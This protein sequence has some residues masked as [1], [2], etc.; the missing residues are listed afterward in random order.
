MKVLLLRNVL[1]GGIH[2]QAGSTHDLGDEDG[3][4]LIRMGKAKINLLKPQP[5]RK[6][7][8]ED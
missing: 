7:K 6:P 2:F 1:V 8:A 5:L 4:L 3:E